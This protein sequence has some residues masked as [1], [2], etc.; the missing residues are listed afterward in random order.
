MAI[1]VSV[2]G[3][4]PR[5]P[6]ECAGCS[7]SKRLVRAELPLYASDGPFEPDKTT[8]TMPAYSRISWSYFLCR[9]CSQYPEKTSES[10]HMFDIVFAVGIV[11]AF[12]VFMVGG[13][14]TA[15]IVATATIICIYVA[16]RLLYRR[17]R[18]NYIARLAERN[19]SGSFL[20]CVRIS[21]LNGR[22]IRGFDTFIELLSNGDVICEFEFQNAG[23]A[24]EFRQ[25][26]PSTQTV[27]VRC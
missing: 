18:R 17:G 14:P 24:E 16:V 23:Y 5:W 3:R 12:L 27:A 8:E 9:R 15:W 6:Q 26:N 19:E 11:I 21:R 2:V 7:T 20:K 25:L 13:M 1:R 4:S 22:D 10:I